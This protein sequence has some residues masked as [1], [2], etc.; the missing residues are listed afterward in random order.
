M[1]KKY[2]ILWIC[3]DQQRSDTLGCMGNPYVNTPNLDR[4]ADS[5]ML[6]EQAY[7]QN[8]TCSPSRASF[9]TGRY[10][11]TTR[12][13]QNGQ[14]I[15]PSERLI[16]KLFSEAGYVCGLAGKLHINPCQ[17]SVCKGMEERIDDGYDVFHWSHGAHDGW[18]T[19]EY[20]QWLREQGVRFSS[21][22]VPGTRLVQYG[23]D[24]QHHQTKWCTDKAINFIR[25]NAEYG[26]NWFFSVNYYDPHHPFDPPK[27]YLDRYI[28][29]LDELPMP[30]YHS[31]ELGDKPLFQKMDHKGAYNKHDSNNAAIIFDEMSEYD[32]KVVKAAYY[33]MI[34][35]IDKQ[36]GRLLDVLRETGELERTIVIFHSDHGEMLGDHG[37]YLKGPY[38]YE[39][40]VH[41]PLIIS[42]PEVI[43][44]GRHVEQ[45]VELIDLAPT[46]VEAVQ[47]PHQPQM[48]GRSMW[49]LLTGGEQ[50]MLH[51]KGV[52]SEY[53][54][55]MPWH[56]NPTAQ[57]TM[58]FDG[59]YKVVDVHSTEEGEL[60]DLENDPAETVN[61]WYNPAYL[62]IKAEMLRKLCDAMAFTC[63]PLPERISEW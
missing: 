47:L 30:N 32:H 15:D 18:A 17:P 54:N 29:H 9:L 5:G 46:L 35:L 23:M 16:S 14:K 56:K 59:R 53:Y 63:D 2:N 6:F 7:C 40:A 57:C 52:Y 44:A 27:E 36:V 21:R 43:P 19:H 3:T 58:F 33:A 49:K 10:P 13:R 28:N 24:E 25:A 26:N 50:P 20:F 51:P 41:V 39:G 8:P 60:Y 34:D 37:I 61:L 38:F 12:C 62:A 48:Q 1:N 31:G 22:P 11:R 42:C 4:L 55:S 45:L